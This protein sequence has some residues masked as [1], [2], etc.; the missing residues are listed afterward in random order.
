MLF[1]HASDM[2]RTVISTQLS[3]QQKRRGNRI[4]E[5][6]GNYDSECDPSSP[7]SIRGS[8]PLFTQYNRLLI[9]KPTS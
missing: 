3:P 1:Q 8:T 7:S 4:S 5:K 6:L 2:F 9:D